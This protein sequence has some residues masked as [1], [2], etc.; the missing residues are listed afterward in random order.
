MT[1]CE[2]LL[3]CEKRQSKGWDFYFKTGKELWRV[4]VENYTKGYFILFLKANI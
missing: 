4:G 1:V 3:L 2:R